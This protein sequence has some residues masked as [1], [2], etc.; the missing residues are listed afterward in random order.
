M[1]LLLEAYPS[2]Q[3]HNLAIQEDAIGFIQVKGLIQKICKTEEE[4]LG[5]LFEGDTN[6]TVS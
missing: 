5:V 2:D 6:R 3:P 4:A 1:D